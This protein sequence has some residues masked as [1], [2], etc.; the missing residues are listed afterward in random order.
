MMK[1]HIKQGPEIPSVVSDLKTSLKKV[2]HKLPRE[3][4]NQHFH[5]SMIPMNY[6]NDQHENLKDAVVV[7]ILQ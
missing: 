6:I 4:S 3:A 7:H 5:P 2:P 1:E